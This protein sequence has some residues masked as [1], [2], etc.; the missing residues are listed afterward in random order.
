MHVCSIASAC[1]AWPLKS[2]CTLG[3]AP[4]PHESSWHRRDRYTRL[5]THMG[6]D[7]RSPYQMKQ[8]TRSNPPLPR[9]AYD[10]LYRGI[11]AMIISQ[12]AFHSIYRIQP[13]AY[14]TQFRVQRPESRSQDSSLT[15]KKNK[16]TYKTS[17]ATIHSLGTGHGRR[18]TS[19][20]SRISNHP[21][22]A[23]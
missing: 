21:S 11:L 8:I 19:H 12:V 15:R 7:D 10:T 6:Q 13:P 1:L 17:R 9:H 14:P 3:I 16:K 20:K 4:A 5:S 2:R 23:N 18:A 22:A